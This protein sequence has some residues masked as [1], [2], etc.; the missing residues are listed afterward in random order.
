MPSFADFWGPNVNDY[1]L[2]NNRNP[3]RTP[4][5]RTAT[6]RSFKVAGELFDTLVGATAGGAALATHRRIGNVDSNTAGNNESRIVTDTLINRNS[7]A[8][9]VTALKALV[10]GV[11]NRPAYPRDLSGNGGG[12]LA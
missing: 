12:T 7:A 5:R 9:D 8:A 1:R 6:A 3:R 2:L 10:F 11:R 4:I